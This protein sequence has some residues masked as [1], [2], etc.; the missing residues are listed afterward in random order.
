MIYD[1]LTESIK[2]PKKGGAQKMSIIL[3]ELERVP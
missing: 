3:V 1:T 2:I